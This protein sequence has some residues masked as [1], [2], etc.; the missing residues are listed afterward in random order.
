MLATALA[1]VEMVRDPLDTAEE[2]ERSE[3][4]ALHDTA[5]VTAARDAVVEALAALGAVVR[6]GVGA[7][8]A[9]LAA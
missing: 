2:V 4:E 5:D 3:A 8:E 9:G 1:L 7:L 6:G